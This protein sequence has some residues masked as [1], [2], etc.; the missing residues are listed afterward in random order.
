VSPLD[1][2]LL[3]DLLHLRGQ[4]IAIAVVVAC[5]VSMF[6]TLRS[7]HRYLLETQAS[8]Y[9]EYRFA[10]LFAQLKRAP[11]STAAAIAALPGVTA[12]EPRIVVDV[13]VDVPGLPEPA[14]PRRLPAPTAWRSATPS[15]R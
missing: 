4:M 6:V 15:E 10:G 1:R 13:L 14:T 2:K 11:L 5:G 9:E 12:V 3:R 7:M 8:Y